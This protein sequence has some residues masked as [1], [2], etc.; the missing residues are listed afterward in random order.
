MMLCLNVKPDGRSP[1][2][3]FRGAINDL[4]GPHQHLLGVTP[5][6]RTGAAV[7]LAFDYGDPVVGLMA[8]GGHGAD[9][10]YVKL[11]GH[12][13]LQLVSLGFL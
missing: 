10:D 4:G 8:P 2:L 1:F 11:M 12:G 13:N 9:N 6:E 3:A 7:S 5:P